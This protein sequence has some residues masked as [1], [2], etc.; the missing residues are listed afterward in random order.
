MICS[1][2]DRVA[3]PIAWKLQDAI[4]AELKGTEVSLVIVDCPDRIPTMWQELLF[5]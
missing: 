1:S 3:A 5:G 2:L 4:L